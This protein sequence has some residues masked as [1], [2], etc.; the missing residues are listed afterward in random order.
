[1]QGSDGQGISTVWIVAHSLSREYDGPA[2]RG[3]G[4]EY[5]STMGAQ[6]LS[7]TRSIDHEAGAPTHRQ[8]PRITHPSTL[9]SNGLGDGAP[10]FG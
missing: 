6:A 4:A 9:R 10:L 8:K 7:K 5:G 2:A 3:R 1:M